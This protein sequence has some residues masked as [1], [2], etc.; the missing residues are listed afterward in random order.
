[1]QVALTACGIACPRDSDMQ[2]TAFAEAIT[3]ARALSDLRRGDLLFWKGHVAMARDAST[4]IHANA[5]HMAV[6]IEPI[7]EAVARVRTAGSELTSVRRI[8]RC[9]YPGPEA[10]SGQ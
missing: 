5:F 8:G 4:L 6:A 9:V 7:A 3:S 1:V 2:E 10:T